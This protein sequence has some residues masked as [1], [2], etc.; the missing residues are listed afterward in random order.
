MA[1]NIFK[2]K[3]IVSV[4][5]AT[6]LTSRIVQQQTGSNCIPKPFYQIGRIHN[7]GDKKVLDFLEFS[8]PNIYC[9][10]LKSHLQGSDDKLGQTLWTHSKQ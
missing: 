8:P 6:K 7:A 2:S 4:P 3:F 1:K 9:L 5:M 10:I